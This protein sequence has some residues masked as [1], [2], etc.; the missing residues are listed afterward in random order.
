MPRW[1]ILR[2]FR[3]NMTIFTS[4]PVGKVKKKIRVGI[5][6]AK[7]LGSVGLGETEDFF[8][9]P[10]SPACCPRLDSSPSMMNSLHST[11]TTRATD[12]LTAVS[13]VN[14]N[15]EIKNCTTGFTNIVIYN[16]WKNRNNHDVRNRTKLLM[17]TSL[18]WIKESLTPQ[19]TEQG[20]LYHLL[21]YNK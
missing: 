20:I 13:T 1:R 7:K 4:L 5:F 3:Y 15:V 11:G 6:G 17:V 8:F 14:Q 9:K 18:T 21:H 10:N 2:H 16:I 12:A 19:P